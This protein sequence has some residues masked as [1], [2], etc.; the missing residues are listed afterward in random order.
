M[1]DRPLTIF[2]SAAEASGDLH[3][4]NL[5][6]ALRKRL[7]NARFVGAAG[8]RMADA[9]C[10]VVTDLTEQGSMLG[11][12]FF[13]LAFWIRKVRQLQRAIR[14]IQPDLHVPTDSPALN[15]HLAKVSKSI[16]TDVF[17]YVAPQVWA[18]APWRIKKVR[19]LTDHVACILPFEQRY[20]R[21]RG[22]AAT[23][24]GHPLMDEIPAQ[25][26][27]LPDI[28]DAWA[29][30]AWNV[31]LVPGSREGEIRQH[32]PAM[33]ATARR[34]LRKFPSS[35]CT[36]TARNAK[37]AECLHE[38]LRAEMPEG[39]DIAVDSLAEVLQRSHFAVTVSGTVTLEVAHFG[40]PMLVLYRVG[41]LTRKLHRLGRGWAVKVPSFSLV[42][43]L[44]GRKMVRE[45]IP[46]DGN[47][48]TISDAVLE[49]LSEPGYLL[50]V[51]DELQGL[52]RPLRVPAPGSASDNAAKLICDVLAERRA[53]LTGAG[54]PE[55]PAAIASPG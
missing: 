18:W 3:A 29:D 13:R 4:A 30:G 12:P 32:A 40:V 33:L 1:P 24:V 54:Q 36:F 47:V 27:E 55:E 26:A 52:V 49:V 14:E 28:A 48:R 43:L 31:A 39:V 6:R 44:A 41:W 46:W 20:F 22:V 35:R 34:I 23:Y 15:W 9:G 42:N 50:K 17:Y 37:A 5:I 16:G 45:I 8:P 51:R 11:G 10:E 38:T 21:D 19:R 25:P 7:P 53:R 2:F